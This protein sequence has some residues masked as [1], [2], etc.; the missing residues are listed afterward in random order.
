MPGGQEVIRYNLEEMVVYKKLDSYSQPEW[1][2]KFVTD[3]TL[4]PVEERLPEEP[5]VYM[6]SGMSN[7]P[8]VYG[9]VWRDFSAAPTQGWNIG[10][11][12]SQGWFGIN[13]VFQES[14]VKSGPMFLRNDKAEP[15]PNLAQSWEWSEDGKV[16]TMELISGA[17]WSDGDPFDSEDVM[18][19]WEDLILDSNVRSWTSRTSHSTPAR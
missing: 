1:M 4:P 16:L 18:F 11:G 15:F 14:L 2:D 17:K 9:G 13:Y 7:G 10:A 8:G 12:Q 19:T 3:G 5:Q 6:T